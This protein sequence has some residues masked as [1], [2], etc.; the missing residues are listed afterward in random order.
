[1]KK[2]ALYILAFLS[3]VFAGTTVQ[4]Q[5]IENRII[6]AVN[7]YDERD[8]DGAAKI[9]KQILSEQPDNDAANY[10]MGLVSVY[11]KNPEIAKAYMKEAVRL[12]PDN[13]WYRYRLAQIY[14][15]NQ[16]PEMTVS[17]EEN[18]LK[19]FPKKNELYYELIELYI[20]QGQDEKALETLDQIETVFG[21]SEAV[22]MTKFQLLNKMNRQEEGYNALRDFNKK[23]SSASVS[24][25]LGDYE[26]SMYHDTTALNLYNEALD[27]MPGFPGALIG[28]AEVYRMNRNYDKFFPVVKSFI[29]EPAIIPVA[30]AEYF[31]AL[32][33]RSDPKFVRLFQNQFDSLVVDCIEAHPEDSIMLSTVGMYYYS[34]G[35]KDK[36]ESIFKENAELYPES[37]TAVSSYAEM[38]L[39]MGKW[40]DAAEYC[41]KQSEKFPKE[42]GFLEIAMVAYSNMEDFAKALDVTDKMVKN[43]GKDTS[44]LVGIYSAQGD[45]HFQTNNYKSAYKSYDKAL[46]I[47]PR[48]CPVLNNYAYYLSMQGKKLKKAYNMSKITVEKEPDNP[49]YLDTFAWI[50]YLQGKS[51][52]AKPFFKHAM[53]YGGKDSAVILDHYAEVLFALKEY[54]LAFLYWNQAL[55]KNNDEIPDLESKIEERKKAAGVK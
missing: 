27:L 23:Y 32:V 7:C 22:V 15:L 21:P 24:S 54:D 19:D 9:L 3:F 47:N 29:K 43:A 30:K 39:Y 6:D 8:F 48:Y 4:A 45:L 11:Q 37:L 53:L 38:L 31:R 12:D 1:M 52:E 55:S 25:V 36:A 2:I 20:K 42:P 49:T 41:L 46:K 14:L 16:E 33:S 13:Y 28:K 44:R 50:L 17:I 10:Y 40:Q 18:L 5:N 51:L 34:T 26:L 35:R